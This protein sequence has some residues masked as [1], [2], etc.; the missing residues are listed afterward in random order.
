MNSV[1][2]S[3]TGLLV[4]RLGYMQRGP[5]SFGVPAGTVFGLSGSS[6]SGK[7]LLLRALCDLDPTTGSVSLNGLDCRDVSGPEWRQNV[8]WLPAES[9]WWHETVGAHFWHKLPVAWVQELGFSEDVY[10]WE[11]SRLST[12]E[13]QRLAILRL[14]QH[15]P[16]ALLLDEPTASLD[17]GNIAAV[18]KFIQNYLRERNGLAVWVSHDSDQLERVAACHYALQ[19][20]GSMRQL[21]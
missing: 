18:E 8:A 11:I 9:L 3:M 5:Y 17:K 12:G 1:K 13:K 6:G 2:L 7:T 20:D 21:R 15:H 16:E 19:L 14:L 4:D 10:A